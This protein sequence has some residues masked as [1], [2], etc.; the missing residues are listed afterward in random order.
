[1]ILKEGYCNNFNLEL[2]S[3]NMYGWRC[4]TFLLNI[5]YLVMEIMSTLVGLLLRNISTVVYFKIS[6]IIDNKYL[7]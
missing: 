2:R 3:W 6:T 7:D 4:I 5:K 1:M